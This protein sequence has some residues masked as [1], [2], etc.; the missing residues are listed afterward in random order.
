MAIEQDGAWKLGSAF[1]SQ[2]CLIAQANVIN[3]ANNLAL[4]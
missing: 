3:V 4:Y 1:V 2:M